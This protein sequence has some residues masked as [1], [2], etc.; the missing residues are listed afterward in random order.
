MIKMGK[1]KFIVAILVA[2]FFATL[3]V[4]GMKYKVLFVNS[5][6]VKIGDRTAKTG[7][8]FDEE[9]RITWSSDRQALKVQNLSNNRLMV[10]AAKSFQ[11]KESKS[12][13]DY[14]GRVKHLSTRGYS[15]RMVVTD[16]VCFMLDTLALDAGEMKNDEISEDIIITDGKESIVRKA[17]R[18]PDGKFYL[19]T[20][21]LI[22]DRFKDVVY[23][24]ICVND[25][26]RNWIYDVYRR[27]RIE[28]LP[29]QTK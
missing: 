14:L 22:T 8:V 24:D 6:T 20:R 16:T 12:L 18:S 15:S 19:I 5:G 27:Q 21:D 26:R 4:N 13:A 7:M 17:Q 1:R 23:V 11:K 29:L 10:I 25:H 28:I 2:L 9:E 3:P